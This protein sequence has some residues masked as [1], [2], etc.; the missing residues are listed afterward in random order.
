MEELIKI[1]KNEL[2]GSKCDT[3][4]AKELHKFLESKQ[5]FTDWIKNRIKKYD[6]KYDK[7]FISN[8]KLMT[9]T[10]TNLVKESHEYYLSISMAKE[11][12]M[13]ENNDKGREARKYFIDCEQRLLKIKDQFN[14]ENL[15]RK[16]I[17]L[18]ALEAEEKAEQL[19]KQIEQDKPYTTTGKQLEKAKD[20]NIKVQD[21]VKIYNLKIGKKSVGRNSFFEWLRKNEILMDD[22]TP[23][24]KYIDRNY[25]TV[26][27]HVITN[28][29]DIDSIILSKTTLITPKGQIWLFNL[30]EEK[31]NGYNEQGNLPCM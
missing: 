25:F 29:Q 21:F 14:P 1:S 24:Q 30:W 27:Q 3:V 7:D 19:E 10:G 28:E 31:Q 15:T 13:V 11:L 12:S 18:I 6:F 4:N 22:N 8:H 5:K 20:N 23:Y 26:Y 17:I 2:N 9:I 16:Q